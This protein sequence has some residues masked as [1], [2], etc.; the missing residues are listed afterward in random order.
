MNKT[1]WKVLEKGM[2][3][4]YGDLKWKVGEW[5]KNY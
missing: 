3:S 5:K 2:K 1:A 4:S